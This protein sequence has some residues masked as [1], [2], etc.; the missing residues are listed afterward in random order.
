[1]PNITYLYFLKWVEFTFSSTF[2]RF[3]VV[4][5]SAGPCTYG[6]LETEEGSVSSKTIPRLRNVMY[7][8][9]FTADKV[10]THDNFVGQLSALIGIIVEHLVAPDVRSIDATV[11]MCQL[12][13]FWSL[14]YYYLIG[15]P[16]FWRPT[17]TY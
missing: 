15:S 9:G 2:I 8:K 1:M 6:R 7:P 3:V 11:Y 5:I 16:I 10:T 17:C 4:D 13:L 14:L 12:V